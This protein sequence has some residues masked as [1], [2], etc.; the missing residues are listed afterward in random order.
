VD[1][2]IDKGIRV[3]SEQ[4]KIIISLSPDGDSAAL[5]HPSGLVY[6]Y[7]SRVEITTTDGNGNTKFAKMFYKG[8]SFTSDTSA[9]VYLVDQ[10]GTRTTSDT[11]SDLGGDFSIPV[12]LYNAHYGPNMIPECTK[13]LRQA[14]YWITEDGTENW[15]V[16]GI[17]VSQTADGLVRVGRGTS[18]YQIRTSPNNGTATITT[19][20]VHSTASIGVPS[21]NN[22]SGPHLFVKRGERRL[23]SDGLTFIVRNAGHAS[24]FDEFNQLKVY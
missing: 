14:Q 6:A 8:V 3:L 12:F 22:S 9:L 4:S 16:N 19:P 15:V 10:A 24:G 13:I 17:R 18:K 5:I 11:F 21:T 2:T 7:G 1:T 20:S 23:H